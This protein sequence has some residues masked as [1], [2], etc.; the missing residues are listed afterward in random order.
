MTIS[1]FTIFTQTSD[2][3]NISMEKVWFFDKAA[4]PLAVLTSLAVLIMITAYFLKQS[5]SALW[6]QLLELETKSKHQRTLPHLPRLPVLGNLHQLIYR[7]KPIPLFFQEVAQEV[8][9]IFTF[10]MGNSDLV[11]VNDYDAAMELLK[12]E[13]VSQRPMRLSSEITKSYKGSLVS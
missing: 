13:C 6:N 7:R 3:G 8:G 2:T 12:L 10:S 1:S 9:P 5:C 11:V 4:N